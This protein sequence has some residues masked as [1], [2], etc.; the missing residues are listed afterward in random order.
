MKAIDTS[1]L[2]K[3]AKQS[4]RLIA[5]AEA[6]PLRFENKDGRK[7]VAKLVATAVPG[8]PALRRQFDAVAH[9][10]KAKAEAVLKKARAAAIKNARSTKSTLAAMVAARLKAFEVLAQPA[11]NV[12]STQYFLL[13]TPFEIASTP[14]LPLSGSQIVPSNS[15]AKFTLRADRKDPKVSASFFYVWVNSLDKYVVINVHGYMVFRGHCFVGVDGGFFPGDH[16]VKLKIDARLDI[17]DWTNEPITFPS[18]PVD[19]SQNVLTMEESEGGWMSVGALDARD[20]FRGYDLRHSLLVVP[21]RAT[22]GFA[23]TASIDCTTGDD[24]GLIDVDFASGNFQVMS[25]A[26]LVAVVS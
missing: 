17:F 13:N 19:Q 14:G 6:A 26:V 15:W 10:Q 20:V 22:I 23:M 21:P 3:K 18:A 12:P 16:Y 1:R 2:K 8:L 7:A 11:T 4:A 25:P 9:K 24:S 5:A